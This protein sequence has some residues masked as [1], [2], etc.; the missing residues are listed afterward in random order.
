MNYLLISQIAQIV[1][2]V[3]LVFFTLIQ[4]KGQGLSSSFA[5]NIGFYRSRRGLEK[6]IFILTILSA[7]L[8]VANS[9]V[10]VILK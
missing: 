5:G 6:G 2:A 10:I 9:L 8:L 7:V 3:S 1:L 4:S